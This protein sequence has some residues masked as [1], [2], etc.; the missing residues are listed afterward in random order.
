M[1]ITYK[2]T[3]D[4][5]LSVQKPFALRPGRNAGFIAAVCFCALMG[6]LGVL[7]IV[8]GFGNIAGFFI[9]GLGILAFVGA[10]LFE[11]RAVTNRKNNYDRK[12]ALA[13]QQI[14]C[15]DR[16]EFEATETRFTTIC[17]CGTVT[18]PWSELSWVTD[19]KSFLIVGS[20]R[21]TEPL[22]KSAFASEG[23]LTEF[24][25]L[26]L[27]KLNGGQS[28]LIRQFEFSYA[29]ADFRSAHW[30]HVW[31]AGGKRNLLLSVVR[32]W[33]VAV[34]IFFVLTNMKGS[35]I[36]EGTARLIAL[37]GALL[38]LILPVFRKGRT[39]IPPPARIHY[40]QEGFHVEDSTSRIRYPWSQFI[41]Y[42]ENKS[43]FLLYINPRQYKIIP[44]RALK[45]R[46]DEF[47]EIL[48]AKVRMYD[49]RNPV[50]TARN[51]LGPTA[52][53]NRT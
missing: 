11:K 42:L 14:H 50:P 6:A 8:Q 22:P 9:I 48:R 10:W 35:N 25:S 27:E 41:G 53:D 37:G 40:D 32:A 28:L 23:E 46:A 26:L 49:Y 33:G 13:F 24:R 5:F 18:R 7:L 21:G 4:D 1:R 47:C 43:A 34:I 19:T 2:V 51:S 45:N 20:K 17:N 15:R 36:S 12:L 38:L 39:H 30:L 52:A 3:W 29:R 31:K 44:K 16:R